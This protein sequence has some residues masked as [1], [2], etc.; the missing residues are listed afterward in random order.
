M[1]LIPQVKFTGYPADKLYKV[2]EPA[3]PAV[4]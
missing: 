3:L 4:I 2:M 1:L